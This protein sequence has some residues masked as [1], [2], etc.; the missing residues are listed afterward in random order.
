M[1]V[2]V[3]KST[4]LY[5][6]SNT[7]CQPP[8]RASQ[9][10]ASHQDSERHIFDIL[11]D[12]Y[13]KCLFET[14]L[15]SR[16]GRTRFH[17]SIDWR[18]VIFENQISP[19]WFTISTPLCSRFFLRARHESIDEWR[20]PK[21]TTTSNRYRKTSGN[22]GLWRGR[23]EAFLGQMSPSQSQYWHKSFYIGYELELG[24]IGCTCV[25]FG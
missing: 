16:I 13:L 5:H 25:S 21:N 15:A 12:V 24:S 19:S 3:L 7:L 11:A 4:L 22:T 23:V 1:C 10:P 8:L 17:R 2:S 9:P 6:K 20:V 18:W 14:F